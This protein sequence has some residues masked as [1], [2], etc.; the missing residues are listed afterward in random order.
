MKFLKLHKYLITKNNFFYLILIYWSN[1]FLFQLLKYFNFLNNQIYSQI[2]H[3]N[4]Y[5][6]IN[7]Y[8]NLID[9]NVIIEVLKLLMI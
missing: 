9:K 2:I 6:K 4:T 1:I 7:V 3:K 5:K 8:N